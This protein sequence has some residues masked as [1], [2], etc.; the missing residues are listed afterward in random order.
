[1]ISING[2]SYRLKNRLTAIERETEVA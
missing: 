2:P 1:M